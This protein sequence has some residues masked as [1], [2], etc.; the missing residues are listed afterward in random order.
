MAIGTINWAVLHKPHAASEAFI[1]L[2]WFC[3]GGSGGGG[4]GGSSSCTIIHN[5]KKQ[6]MQFHGGSV[7][8]GGKAAFSMISMAL[9]PGAA[10]VILGFPL[11][12][13][14]GR[15]MG[16]IG[17]IAGSLAFSFFTGMAWL[18]YATITLHV[19]NSQLET[20]AGDLSPGFSFA[21]DVI[22]SVL[23]LVSCILFILS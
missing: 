2:L 8:S 10:A 3:I 18:L 7:S 21:F 1:G 23:S 13:K 12:L 11:I 6:D 9:L 17:A 15:G 16:K 5:G 4:S 19:N 14:R 20:P 22:A